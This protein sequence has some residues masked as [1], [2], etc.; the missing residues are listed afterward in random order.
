[1]EDGKRKETAVEIHRFIVALSACGTK[2]DG[3][4][5]TKE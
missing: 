2:R 1:M 5:P 4:R 3:E